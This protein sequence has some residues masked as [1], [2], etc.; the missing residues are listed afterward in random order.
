MA[1]VKYIG[2]KLPSGLFLDFYK[3]DAPGAAR[4]LSR[5]IALAG[6]N[7]YT[8]KKGLVG[9]DNGGYGITAVDAD[10]WEEWKKTHVGFD[11]L[12]NG[13]IFEVNKKEDAIKEGAQRESVLNGMEGARPTQ[14]DGVE[15]VGDRK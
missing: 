7:A 10:S 3:G 11:P 8:D 4:D 12:V 1:G 6:T 14:D 13:L 15:D 2:C 9:S 5:R